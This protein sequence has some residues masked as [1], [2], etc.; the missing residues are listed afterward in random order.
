M[1]NQV[2][3]TIALDWSVEAELDAVQAAPHNH[4]VLFEND[5]VRV[6]ES[7]VEPGHMVP[8]HMH[9]WPSSHYVVSTSDFVRRDQDGRI[10]FD[11]RINTEEIPADTAFWSEPLPPHTVENVGKTELRTIMVEIKTSGD[12][13]AKP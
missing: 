8:L 1:K 12:R 4:I 9:P 2:S 3:S 6:L 7:Y 5:L 10:V 11:T 13:L